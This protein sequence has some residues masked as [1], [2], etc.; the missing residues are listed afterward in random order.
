MNTRAIRF[1]WPAMGDYLANRATK[2]R[3]AELLRRWNEP[4]RPA[5]L[6]VLDDED[7]FADVLGEDDLLG[8]FPNAP[9][10]HAEPIGRIAPGI[11]LVFVVDKQ[12]AT[13]HAIADPRG[14]N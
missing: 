11:L 2:V 8:E 10:I 6:L 4:Q 14:L 12:G 3:I 5:V 9:V 7:R 1:D 13:I